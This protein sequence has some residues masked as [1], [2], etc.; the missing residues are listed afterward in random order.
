MR[1]G[2]LEKINGAL[3]KFQEELKSSYPMFIGSS[4]ISVKVKSYGKLLLHALSILF[5]FKT[6]EWVLVHKPF[7]FSPRPCLV[8]NVPC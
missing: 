6:Y 8:T 1:E 3:G 7:D 5:E 4:K 2:V